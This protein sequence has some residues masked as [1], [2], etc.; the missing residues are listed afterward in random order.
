[1][2]IE[3]GGS[4]EAF[5]RANDQS[6]EEPLSLGSRLA[7]YTRIK[8]LENAPTPAEAD[9]RPE[10]EFAVVTQA[11]DVPAKRA[12]RGRRGAAALVGVARTARTLT[13]QLIHAVIAVTALLTR[14]GG[15]LMHSAVRA[16]RLCARLLSRAARA[17]ALAL[18]R[19]TVTLG[20]SL[21]L[22]V[23]VGRLFARFG[24]RAAH[25]LA[26]TVP[27]AAAALRRW[28]R[29]ALHV[30]QL[31]ARFVLRA[32]AALTRSQRPV[33]RGDDPP[34]TGHA[35]E[36]VMTWVQP[37]AGPSDEPADAGVRESD[38]GMREAQPP[39][40]RSRRIGR[41]PRA[42][43]ALLSV[44]VAVLAVTLVLHDRN[45][46]G[47]P[48]SPESA[49]TATPESV[50]SRT[51][52]SGPRA[53]AVA[54]TQLALANGRTHLDGKPTCGENSTWE[55]WTC[56]A[57]GRSTLGPYA[58]RWFTYRCSPSYQPQPGGRPAAL[59]VNCRP[60][61]PTRLAT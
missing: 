13:H 52:Y 33:R 34:E 41:T 56:R 51:G 20:R 48:Q 22:A 44:V 10:P 43:L 32:T 6:S 53:Y 45:Q 8:T 27:R 39:E 50:A 14:A 1:V 25:N 38:V 40:Y 3:L 11:A 21:R 35:A 42:G 5:D 2:L 31:F 29:L 16:A 23:H 9:L 36:L 59:M 55:H 15:V 19:A 57:K 17:L 4:P 30:G 61:S 24:L 58:G 54:M 18:A 46:G 37:Q 12:A 47:V 26:V 7:D 60:E 49:V 28:L